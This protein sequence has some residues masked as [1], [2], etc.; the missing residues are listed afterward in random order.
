MKSRHPAEAQVLD[1]LGSKVVDGLAQM[2]AQTRADLRTYRATFPTW[3]AEST[4]RGLLNWCH[5]RL[6]AYAVRLFDDSPE[7][8]LKDRAPTREITVGHRYRLRIKK[9]D[10][11]GKVSTYPTQGAL[12]FLA[13]EQ[14][15][16]E[17][18]DE[19]HL[20]AG[21]RWDPELR[22]IGAAVISMR[23]SQD[24]ILWL[25]E[26]DEPAEGRG[27]TTTPILPPTMGPPAPQI[28]SASDDE[29]R[30]GTESG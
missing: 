17:G 19:V 23:D 26:L 4:D 29:R 28:G 30:E 13:Q 18:L 25:R 14:L 1:D 6:W 2:V 5:D 20:I 8:T 22:D 12:A 24:N 11:E 27:A 16:L 7:I 15:A 3:V 10:P 21:Y 9:H